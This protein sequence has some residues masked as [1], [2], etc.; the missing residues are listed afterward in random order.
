YRR[1]RWY[2]RRCALPPCEADQLRHRTR[3]REGQSDGEEKDRRP[4]PDDRQDQRDEREHPERQ[5]PLEIQVILEGTVADRRDHQ[6]RERYGEAAHP[7]TPDPAGGPPRRREPQGRDRSGGRRYRQADEVAL[8]DDFGLDVEPGEPHRSA[9]HEEKRGHP[10]RPREVGQ[11]PGVGEHRRRDS[12]RDEIRERIVFFAELRSGM[13]PAG[14]AAV[15]SVEHR[16]RDDEDGRRLERALDRPPDREISAEEIS[17]RE[18]CRQPEEAPR[19]PLRESSRSNGPRLV[20]TL[21][22]FHRARPVCPALTL[23][24]SPTRISVASG[25]KTST[26]EPNRIMPTRSPRVKA[27]PGRGQK[28]MRLARTPAI[29][30]NI[31]AP[32]PDSIVMRFCSFSSDAF[33]SKAAIFL[34]GV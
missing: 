31:T 17:D 32:R 15:E 33:E 12:E 28:M 18:E 26:R 25:G 22:H 3:G 6:V 14:D 8:V 7:P 19:K 23:S 34:P 4:Q 11:S 27:S 9:H 16:R 30:L 13:R 20:Q 29:C 5:R 21:V 1:G 24:P 10:A 2:F